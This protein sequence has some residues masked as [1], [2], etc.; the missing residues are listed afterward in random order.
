MNRIV[1]RARVYRILVENAQGDRSG[2]D[3][4]TIVQVTTSSRACTQ[5]SQR[6]KSGDLVVVGVLVIQLFHRFHVAK[7]AVTQLS[8][9][10]EDFHGHEES[11]LALRW[12]FCEAFCCG[13]AESLERFARFGRVHARKQRMVVG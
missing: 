1:R 6:V 9:A 5:N 8:F 13:R 3:R 11:L 4:H 12:R 2:T 10:P 7:A